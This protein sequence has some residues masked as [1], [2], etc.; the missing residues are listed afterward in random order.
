ML[1]YIAGL[2][3]GIVLSIT[4]YMAMIYP[5]QQAQIE[6]YI[7]DAHW[8]GK[9]EVMYCRDDIGFI[10]LTVQDIEELI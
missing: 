7:H 6:Q 10:H 3:I 2:T 9:Q 4:V 8:L 5:K 1:N